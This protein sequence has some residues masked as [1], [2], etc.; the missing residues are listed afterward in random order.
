MDDFYT[1]STDWLYSFPGRI[2]QGLRELSAR[3]GRN[4]GEG[5]LAREAGVSPAAMT[6]WM[7]GNL[8]KRE[9]LDALADVFQKAGLRKFDRWFLESGIVVKQPLQ[10]ALKMPGR[11]RTKVRGAGV[12]QAK[13]KRSDSA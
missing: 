7:Q 12:K 4:V 1:V 9:N 10:R 3:L 5:E 13:R 11:A 8:P 2:K 6:K